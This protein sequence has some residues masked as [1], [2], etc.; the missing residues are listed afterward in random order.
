MLDMIDNAVAESVSPGSSHSLKSLGLAC[1]LRL[2]RLALRA[3]A[4]QTPIPSAKEELQ[5]VFTA[6]AEWGT[7]S[8]RKQGTPFGALLVRNRLP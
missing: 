3:A 1:C 5:G 7:T 4:G 2:K 6:F 8:P